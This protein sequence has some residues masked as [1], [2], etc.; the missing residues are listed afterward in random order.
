MIECHRS[1]LGIVFVHRQR[2]QMGAGMKI[3]ELR[4]TACKGTLNIGDNNQNIVVCE[5]CGS[6]YVIER[7]RSGDVNLK[8]DSQNS[9]YVPKPYEPQRGIKKTGWETY[10]WKR[11]ILLAVLGIVLVMAISWKGISTRLAADKAEKT[12]AKL[13]DILV[14]DGA[15]GTAESQEFEETPFTGVF[16]VMAESVLGKPAD[17]ITEED[18]KR[19]CWLELNYDIEGYQLGYSFENPYENENAVLTWMSFPRD[20]IA[21]E[22]EQLSRFKGL[23]KLDIANHLTAENLKGLNLEGLGCYGKSPDELSAL[24]DKPG[25]LKEVITKAGLENLGG[26]NQ[27]ENLER[28]TVNA[29]DLTDL[30]ELVNLKTLKSL[31]LENSDEISDYSV[32]SVMP[33]LEEVSIESEGLKDIGFVSMME[34]LNS[35]SIFDAKL[36]TLAELKGKTSLTF[37][38]VEGCDELKDCSSVSGL[39][40]LRQLE[41]EVPYDCTEPDLSALTQLQSLYIS[42]FES[43]GFLRNLSNLEKMVLES[44]WIDNEDAF[45]G[46][47]QLKELRCTAVQGGATGWKFV[48]H[49]PALEYLNLTGISSFDDMSGLFNIPTLVSLIMNGVECEINFSRLQDNQSLRTLELDGVT[50]YKNVNISGGN[51][52]TYVDYDDV[53]LDGQTEFLVHYPKLEQLSLADNKLTQINFASKLTALKNLDIS[54]NY[55][56]DLKPLES[57]AALQMVNCLDNPVENYRVLSEDIYIIK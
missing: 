4:C 39:T 35:L 42:G 44:C 50:L 17:S 2:R 53:A 38:K 14:S 32:L 26:L 36:L 40:N 25:E 47:T 46:L 24:V 43:T 28:L 56:T 18:L 55:I 10:G 45:A 30:K 7:E 34:N 49:I 16:A 19:F 5:Y 57:L 48:E 20:Q 31:T 41:L 12:A 54:G 8:L 51:G 23:K 1:V 9:W 29:S 13:E 33:W 21:E 22:F 52:I 27:F 37:L 6:R 3:T 11:G 15:E